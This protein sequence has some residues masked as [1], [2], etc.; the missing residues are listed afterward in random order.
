VDGVSGTLRKEGDGLP[1]EHFASL[2][3]QIKGFPRHLSIQVGGMVITGS[4]LVEIAPI[5]RATMHGRVVTQWDKDDIEDAGLIKIDLL[6]LR[7]LD[8]IA[9]TVRTIRE[10]DG[11]DLNLSSIELDDP[12]IYQLM[13]EADTI[14]LF[15]VESRAQIA[16]AAQDETDLLRRCHDRG[17]D[18]AARSDLGQDDPSLSSAAAGIGANHLCASSAG[19]NVG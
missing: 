10:N 4:P 17:G 19:A 9:E 16:N 6:S 2:V 11:I 8:V 5:E 18:R 3:E 15:Q 12:A 13:T 7:T 1:W 14:G